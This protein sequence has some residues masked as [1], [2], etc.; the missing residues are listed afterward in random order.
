MAK[1]FPQNMLTYVKVVQTQPLIACPTSEH[2]TVEDTVEEHARY[3]GG[4]AACAAN[5]RRQS[6]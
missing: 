2:V 6:R 3:A 1:R 4:Q 5:L